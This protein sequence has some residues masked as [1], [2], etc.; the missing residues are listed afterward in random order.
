MTTQSSCLCVNG[1]QGCA[2]TIKGHRESAQPGN[3][4]F[5]TDQR[6]ARGGQEHL[7]HRVPFCHCRERRDTELR[8]LSSPA[9]LC[10]YAGHK[11][12]VNPR[13]VFT[14]LLHFTNVCAGFGDTSVLCQNKSLCTVTACL[15]KGKRMAGR[16][17][18][19]KGSLL[20]Y[21]VLQLFGLKDLPS[22]SWYLLN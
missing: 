21:L 16:N 20:W 4:S 8:S 14:N 3:L 10:Q 1:V 22:Q 7:R 15:Q 11:P 12:A 2:Q 9:V 19:L 17:I 6:T 5:S 13:G 18:S